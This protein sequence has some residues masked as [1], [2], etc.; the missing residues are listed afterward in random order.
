MWIRVFLMTKKSV[1]L[2]NSRIAFHAKSCTHHEYVTLTYYDDVVNQLLETH[3]MD[4]LITKTNVEILKLTQ[5]HN[6]TSVKYAKPLWRKY[7]YWNWLY[8]EYLLNEP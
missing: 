3:V 8:D 6:K 5:P 2:L 1:A 7:P 4:E